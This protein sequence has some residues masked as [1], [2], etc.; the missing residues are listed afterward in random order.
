VGRKLKNF[1]QGGGS[2]CSYKKVSHWK[3]EKTSRYYHIRKRE[4]ARVYSGEKGMGRKDV[5]SAARH[6]RIC[7]EELEKEDS[8]IQDT[9]FAKKRR[10]HKKVE[11]TYR[12][13]SNPGK[14]Q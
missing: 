8:K 12:M 14:E 1:I 13:K 9:A 7:R 3:G 10:A 2:S 5:N 6:V 11:S 4:S